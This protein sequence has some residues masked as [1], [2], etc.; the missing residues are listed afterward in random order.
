MQGNIFGREFF[1]EM[2]YLL[3][4]RQ[5]SRYQVREVTHFP[6]DE[7]KSPALV[8]HVTFSF[9]NLVWGRINRSECRNSTKLF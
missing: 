4:L 9:E 6:C 8:L 5:N 7:Q 1:G 2:V 3:M